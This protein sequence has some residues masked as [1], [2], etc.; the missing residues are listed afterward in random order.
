VG[1]CW[2]SV[3]EQEGGQEQAAARQQRLGVFLVAVWEGS[4]RSVAAQQDRMQRLGD[5][6]DRNGQVQGVV[7]PGGVVGV[8]RAG[9]TPMVQDVARCRSAWTSPWTAGGTVAAAAGELKDGQT[10][11]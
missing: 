11:A 8:E 1:C 4:D 10:V 3:G 2:Q 6:V 9:L 7:A 5:A